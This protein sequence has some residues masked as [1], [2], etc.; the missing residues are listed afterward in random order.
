[1]IVIQMGATL[2]SASQSARASWRHRQGLRRPDVRVRAA[3]R[4]AAGGT[5]K[6]LSTKACYMYAKEP[7]LGADIPAPQGC[8]VDS[9][10]AER[11]GMASPYQRVQRW[12]E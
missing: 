8:S 6:R 7:S 10:A 12:D 2:A 5:L 1:M 9:D 4:T 11:R 3:A